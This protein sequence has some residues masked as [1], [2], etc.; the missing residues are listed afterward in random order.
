MTISSLRFIKAVIICGGFFY[1]FIIFILVKNMLAMFPE[2][3]TKRLLLRK[4]IPSDQPAIFKGL[5][6]PAVIKYYGVCYTS[7]EAAA[8]Q[9][10][11]YDDLLKDDTGIWWAVCFKRPACCYDWRLRL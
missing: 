10:K 4:I 2:L 3:I 1:V 5:S 11:F 7:F 8:E 9:M 6:D